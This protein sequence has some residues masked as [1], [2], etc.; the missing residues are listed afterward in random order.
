LFA[1]KPHK[2]EQESSRTVK[3]FV[4]KPLKLEQESSRTVK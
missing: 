4:A 2:L 1:A 3:L